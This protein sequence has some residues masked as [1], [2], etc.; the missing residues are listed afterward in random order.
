MPIS[1]VLCVDLK[2]SGTVANKFVSCYENSNNNNR[3]ITY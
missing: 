3:A 1:C 2:K